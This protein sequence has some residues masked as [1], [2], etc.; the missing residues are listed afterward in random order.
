MSKIN[1]GGLRVQGGKGEKENLAIES[2]FIPVSDMCC[3]ILISIGGM[4]EDLAF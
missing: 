1:L 4:T 3:F 2:N